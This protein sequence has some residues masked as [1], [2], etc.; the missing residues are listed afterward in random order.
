[1][2]GIE[3]CKNQK[4]DVFMERK[5]RESERQED[6]LDSHARIIG[7]DIFFI[8]LG[9]YCNRKRQGVKL[10]ILFHPESFSIFQA[11]FF[12]SKLYPLLDFPA[13]NGSLPSVFLCR[14]NLFLSLSPLFLEGKT[15]SLPFTPYHSVSSSI[16]HFISSKQSLA[17][18][19][20]IVWETKENELRRWKLTRNVNTE[21]DNHKQSMKAL[22]NYL[23]FLNSNQALHIHSHNSHE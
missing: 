5:R 23:H 19:S 2:T 3:L 8:L 13:M 15:I 16:H 14:W 11:S 21:E 4:E 10:S 1:M 20:S 12:Q 9:K 17:S 18:Q 7:M 22:L 6:N